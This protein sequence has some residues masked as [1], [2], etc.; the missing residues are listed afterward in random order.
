[1]LLADLIH[2]EPKVHNV[3][4]YIIIF[5]FAL[6]FVTCI[7]LWI[8]NLLYDPFLILLSGD[9]EIN[10]VLRPNSGESFPIFHWNMNSVSV[11]NYTKLFSLYLT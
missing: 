4:M 10:P 7:Y 2:L 1:M 3:A 11:Y 5:T 8:V 9:V 6:F